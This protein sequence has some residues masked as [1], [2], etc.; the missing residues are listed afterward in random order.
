MTHSTQPAAIQAWHQ[1]VQTRD[2]AALAQLLAEDV[3]F[4]SPDTQ[5]HRGAR[6]P[7]VIPRR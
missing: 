2:G 4:E 3:V 6:H 1:V 7:Q 5:G